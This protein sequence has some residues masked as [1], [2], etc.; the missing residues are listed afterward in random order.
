M[1]EKYMFLLNAIEDKKDIL[2]GK[3]SEN[4]THKLKE[5]TWKD[6]VKEMAAHGH[7]IV[8]KECK[9]PPWKYLRDTVWGGNLKCRTL[10]STFFHFF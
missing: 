9:T 10:V 1:D 2:F 6:I 5:D 3:F 7:N 8:Q 4:I